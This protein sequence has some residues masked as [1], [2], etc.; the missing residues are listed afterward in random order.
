MTAPLEVQFDTLENAERKATDTAQQYLDQLGAL[1]AEVES[2]V[3]NGGSGQAFS[4]YFDTVRQQLQPVS[5]TFSG[6]AD[7]IRGAREA[8]VQTDEAIAQG[9]SQ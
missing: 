6:L 4:G 5:E 2:M 8:L 3:W 9:F 7:A 1:E